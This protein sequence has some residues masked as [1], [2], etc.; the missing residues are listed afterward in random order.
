MLFIKRLL[1]A[2][3]LV[4]DQQV[5][6]SIACISTTRPIYLVFGHGSDYPA[7]VIR[8]MNDNHAFHTHRV[9]NHLYQLAG[10]QVP[11]PIGVY[12]YAGEKY[13]VQR[14]VKGA[15]WFQIKSK[16]RTE[17]ARVSLEKRLWQTLTDF[18]YAIAGDGAHKTSDL[19]PHEELRQA[20][21]EYKN[22]EQT[23]NVELEKIV[24]FAISNL[25]Q[26]PGCS[27][28][29]QHGDFCLNNLIIDT[30]HITVI[31]F[32]DFFITTMPMYDHFTLALSLPSCEPEPASAAKICNQDS[33]INMAGILGIS[34]TAIKWH[35]LHHL[36][37]RLG[38]WS[39][40]DKRKPYRTWLIQ[41]LECFLADEGNVRNIAP[42]H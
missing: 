34:R 6:H 11:E 24:K 30:N 8:K 31:D 14:G 1:S 17:D 38:P 28:I 16:I 40:G 36:L 23:V 5:D 7:Y 27:A 22:T 29:P 37:L 21:S 39:V 26:M 32:E 19:Q 9:H 35:F 4:N 25:S 13:D 3:G 12:E 15:P 18:H 2:A 10:N 33:I 20:Y 42:C 41:V